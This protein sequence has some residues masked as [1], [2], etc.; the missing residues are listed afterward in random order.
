MFKR[1]KKFLEHERNV[2][3]IY[4]SKDNKISKRIVKLYSVT[5]QRVTGYCYLRET[6]R[7]FNIEQILAVFPSQK[8]RMK[9]PS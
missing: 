9:E 7:T 4:L 5:E 2:E 1:M 6:V 8:Y 3:M